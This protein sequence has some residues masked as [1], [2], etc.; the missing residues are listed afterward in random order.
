[1][2]QIDTPQSH[3]FQVS[4]S[5]VTKWCEFKLYRVAIELDTTYPDGQIKAMH[6]NNLNS[7][8]LFK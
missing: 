7:F 5:V 8:N 1:M 3:G 2:S 4:G 6:Q